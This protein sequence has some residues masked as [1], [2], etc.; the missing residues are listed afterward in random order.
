VRGQAWAH[1]AIP[2]M[3]DGEFYCLHRQVEVRFMPNAFRALAPA[4]N[5]AKAA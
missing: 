2:A 1:H 3:L 4:A 5:P